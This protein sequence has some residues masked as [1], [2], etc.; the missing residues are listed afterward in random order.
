MTE[1]SICPISGESPQEEKLNFCTHLFGLLLSTIG[2]FWIILKT[3]ALDFLGIASH[4]IYGSSLILLYAASTYYHKSKIL[5]RKRKLKIVDH[6]CIYLLIAGTYTP[7]A[8]GPLRE[9]GGWLLFSVVWS[10][11]IIGITIKVFAL[12]RF[13]KLSLATYL[14]MGWLVLFNFS[15][16]IQSIT[17]SSLVWLVA[18]GL[19]YSAGTLFYAWRSLP[20]NHSIWHLFVMSGSFCH[21]C[22]IL[23][24]CSYL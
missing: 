2:A 23:E 10:L 22:S 1:H 14:A 19:F 13:E 15:T 20:Y 9:E 8:L 24:V 3:L 18:G 5:H 21:Y 17:L 6:C 4:S 7:F 11:A 12:D 16:L